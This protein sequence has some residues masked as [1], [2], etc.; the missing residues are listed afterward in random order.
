MYSAHIS[1]LHIGDPSKPGEENLKRVIGEI[2][3]FCVPFDCVLVT[4]DIVHGSAR[5]HYAEAFALLNEL[6]VPYYLIPGNKDGTDNLIGALR[7]YY[8]FH[9]LSQSCDGL[10]YV[11]DGY[12]LRLVAVDTFKEG[13]MNGAL[14]EERFLWLKNVL[15]DNPDKKPT[16]VMVHQFPFESGLKTFDGGAENWYEKFRYLISDHKDTVRLVACGHLHNPVSG[17]IDGVPVIAAPST[18]WR[19]KYDFV[20]AENIVAE[21]RPLGFYV[22]RW[23]A[24][25]L[26]SYL[27]PVAG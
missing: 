26:T 22:H 24:G 6:K 2:N 17:N 16:V 20:P 1:D 23:D 8:P 5:K 25:Q 9:P 7:T 14:D 11:V 3:R 19:A 18:N 4:G 12:P 13:V 21:V 10:Q 15:A 27:V